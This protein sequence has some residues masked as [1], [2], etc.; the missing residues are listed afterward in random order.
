MPI[1]KKMFISLAYQLI[2][3]KNKH[4]ISKQAYFIDYIYEN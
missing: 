1:K 2:Y 3:I 4:I